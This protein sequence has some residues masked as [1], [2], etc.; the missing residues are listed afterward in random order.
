MKILFLCNANKCCSPLAEGFLK[1]K[2]SNR[3]IDA[4]VDSAGFEVYHV[5]E[6]PDKRA[7]ELATNHGVDISKKRVRLFSIEDFQNF[8]Q[9]YVMDTNSYRNAMYFAQTEED[10][11]KVDYLMN[12]IHP[13]KND[14]FPDPFYRKLDACSEASDI[15]I[16]AITKIADQIENTVVN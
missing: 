1:D 5:N 8:D 7:I 13:D 3:N 12:L 10:K 6:S 14:S 15:M 4:L 2:L 16:K 9:I 11:K